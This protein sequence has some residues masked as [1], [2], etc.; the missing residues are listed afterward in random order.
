MLS[1]FACFSTAAA[2]ARFC[3]IFIDSL[4]A[5]KDQL[6]HV[7]P[8]LVYMWMAACLILDSLHEKASL[9]FPRRP[10]FLNSM[11]HESAFSVMSLCMDAICFASLFE[12]HLLKLSEQMEFIQHQRF[13]RF[14]SHLN[15]I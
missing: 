3:T 9:A 11:Q 2:F 7:L 15:E 8:Y 14:I 13:E 5:S 6:H 10:P 4:I 12:T 1:R